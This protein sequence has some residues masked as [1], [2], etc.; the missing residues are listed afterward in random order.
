[1]DAFPSIVQPIISA[2]G[3]MA[4]KVP[5]TPFHPYPMRLRFCPEKTITFIICWRISPSSSNT[6]MA[7]S[8]SEE[9]QSHRMR[10]ERCYKHF[11][12]H[13]A[14]CTNNRLHNTG[15]SVHPLCF[16]CFV[17]SCL[18]LLLLFVPLGKNIYKT[19]ISKK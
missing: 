17:F 7:F 9:P 19:F 15:E 5:I 11:F 16:C 6:D 18:S 3:S 8:W 1:M 12:V 13:A 4:K 14:V 10:G 2:D